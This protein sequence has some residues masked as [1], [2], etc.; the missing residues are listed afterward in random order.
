MIS[1]GII[2]L[3]H[4]N[5]HMSWKAGLSVIVYQMSLQCD[6]V[7]DEVLIVLTRVLNAHNKTTS[8]MIVRRCAEELIWLAPLYK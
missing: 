5:T 3:L 7:F 2:G 6:S 4:N 8:A 1:F